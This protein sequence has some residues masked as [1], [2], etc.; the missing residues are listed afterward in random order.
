MTTRLTAGGHFRIR[1][2]NTKDTY[3][4]Q[5]LDNDLCQAVVAGK[6]IY[7]RGQVAQDLDTSASVALDDPAGQAR[8]IMENIKQLL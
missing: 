8:K 5:R 1:P 3:P 2:F 7:L 4:D 6:T